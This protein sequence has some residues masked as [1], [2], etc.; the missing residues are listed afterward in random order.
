MLKKILFFIFIP[1]FLFAQVIFE[2]AS[3]SVYNF[4][5]R[6]SVKGIITFNDELRPV[7]RKLI[8]EKLLAAEGKI[9]RLSSVEKEE[10]IYFKRDYY[11]EIQ[12]INS[13]EEKRTVFF[14]DDEE[15]GFRP[16]L[17][18]EKDFSFTVDP[19]LGFT[20]KRQYKEDFKH[21]FNG[22]KFSGYYD[23]FGYNFYF[24]D[25]E[26]S[27]K[28]IDTAKRVSPEPGVVLHQVKK[29]SFDYSSVRGMISFSWKSGSIDFGKDYIEWGS[30]RN[31]QL[32]LSNKAPSFPFIRLIFSPVKWLQFQYFHGW[33]YSG[34]VDSSSIRETLVENRESYS[35]INKFIA[36]HIISLY[37][38]E[39][40]SFSIGESVIYSDKIEP[41]YLI[42]VL[43]FRLADHYNSGSSSGDNAQVFANVVYKFYPLRAKLYSTLF[44]DELSL[45][46][47]LEGGNLS[48]VGFTIGVNFVE[49]LIENSE[50]VLEYTR[51][52]PFVYMNSDN[53]QLYTSHGYQ[54]GH[55]I[56]S[57]ADQF[58]FSYK[59]WI[60]RGLMINLCAEYTSKGQTELPEQQ[61]Q[62]PYPSVLYGPRLNMG[63]L[64][65]EAEYEIFRLLF[66]RLFYQY[67]DISDEEQLRTPVFKWGV[68]H[69]FG[70]S[71]VYGI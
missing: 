8:A 67:L 22:L 28:T 63:K 30:G 24:R 57:N 15:A 35:Q 11:P 39:N 6:L 42:P 27:G 33:L 10:L 12:I 29:N 53:I 18:R 51:L 47:L 3:S 64:G 55:W 2:P 5:N 71:F 56:G 46:N 62:L 13:S 58:Y 65:I 16:F 61:Y 48:S 21:R 70:I 41:I 4:L 66:A 37:P 45:T 40:F 38:I 52:N 60:L 69:S 1:G 32:I 44:I 59:Q 17:Y 20:F 9:N 19:V 54:L 68:N 26:E 50:L 23:N 34:V 7:P 31:G 36:S 43:F 49:P 25:N 14:K